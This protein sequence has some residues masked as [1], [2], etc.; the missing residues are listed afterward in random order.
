M[1]NLQGLLSYNVLLSKYTTWRV[2][3]PASIFYVPKDISDLSVFFQQ[4]DEKHKV[5]FL[6]LGSNVLIRDQGFDGAVIYTH[7]GMK[8]ITKINETTIEVEAGAPCAKVAR[9][10][11]QNGLQGIEFFAGI[12]GTMGGAL[13]L[14]AGAY[15]GETWDYVTS[16]KVIDN[17]GKIIEKSAQ[18]FTPS[19]RKITG[20][21][22]DKQWF[23]SA[24]LNLKP[25]D[26]EHLKLTIKQYL[27]KRV[28]TQPIGQPSCGS[29]FRNPEGDYAAR[30]IQ[31]CDLKGY[32]K[33]NVCVSEKHANFIINQGNATAK[34]IE[35]MILYVQ[36]QVKEKF[37]ITLIPE[38]HII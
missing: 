14:N 33:D 8:K 37:G 32:C 38:V 28:A 17:K 25:G 7:K 23:I 21:I 24:T 27:E 12:P 3:G 18:E 22:K 29:V 10:C 34:S 20:L 1:Q 2:G 13:A 26:I 31:A 16:V 5:L 6:G 4:L 11:A 35:T 30:L 19:Y 36:Q 15:G 9:Y